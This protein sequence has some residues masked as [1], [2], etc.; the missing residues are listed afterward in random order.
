MPHITI[1]LYPGRTEQQKKQLS[2]KVTEAVIET[3]ACSSDAVSV[4]IVDV[5]PENWTEQVYDTEILPRMDVLIK[6]PG[7]EP[8]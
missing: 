1:K 4:D 3:T 8:D 2:D 6:K 7:Y 5:K